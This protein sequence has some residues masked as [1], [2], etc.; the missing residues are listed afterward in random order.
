MRALSDTFSSENTS[1]AHG[2]ST[3]KRSNIKDR[4]LEVSNSREELELN[5]HTVTG[6][7]FKNPTSKVY[8]SLPATADGFNFDL[9]LSFEDRWLVRIIIKLTAGD[10]PSIAR[11]A[12]FYLPHLN[13][14]RVYKYASSTQLRQRN[15]PPIT[16]HLLGDLRQLTT[17]EDILNLL[18]T[19]YGAVF[20]TGTERKYAADIY[21]SYTEC[22]AL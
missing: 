5:Y 7:A 18:G 8:K 22:H 10:L 16:K 17:R 9:T 3:L 15:A 13:L 12:E 11:L 4:I 14:A 6:R 2:K 20:S 19:K 1:P 21:L